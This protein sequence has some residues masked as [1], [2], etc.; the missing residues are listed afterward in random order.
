MRDEVGKYGMF[1]YVSGGAI[2]VVQ[3]YTTLSN[4]PFWLMVLISVVMFTT[5]TGRMSS[6]GALTSAVPAPPSG[7][8]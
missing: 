6:A 5:I 4:A 8:V 2:L 3:F 7:L 1:C